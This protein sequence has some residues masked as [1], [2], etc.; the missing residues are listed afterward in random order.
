M[1]YGY[2]KGFDLSEYEII[3]TLIRFILFNDSRNSRRV[4][5]QAIR[6][7]LSQELLRDKTDV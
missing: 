2:S 3:Y 5:L 6:S 1:N 7:L 4:P